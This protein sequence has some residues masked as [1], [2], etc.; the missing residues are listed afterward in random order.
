VKILDWP[1][2]ERSVHQ[3]IRA[4]R[5]GEQ[6]RHER[7]QLHRTV[8]A[9]LW[10][11]EVDAA[12][13]VLTA[14][15]PGAAAEPVAPLDEAIASLTGQ[16]AWVGDDQ[17]WRDE[18]DPVGSGLVERAVELVINRRLKRRGMRWRRPNATAVVAIQIRVLN[19][20]WEATTRRPAA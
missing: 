4:A 7:W 3:A 11:G 5:P 15:R 12:V 9:H 16:R 8:A 2:L 6:H 14:L 19:P 20:A 13:A 10:R 17:A 18:G 1:H